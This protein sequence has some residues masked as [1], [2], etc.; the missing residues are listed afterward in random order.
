V[1]AA[2][3]ALLPPIG[4]DPW[5]G[6]VGF[7]SGASPDPRVAVEVGG[8]SLFTGIEAAGVVADVGGD[9]LLFLDGEAW[10]F[11]APTADRS[12]GAGGGGDGAILSPMP[13]RVVTVEVENGDRVSKGQRLVVL[14]AMKMEHNLVAPFDGVVG[15]LSVAAGD[16][17]AES[18]LLVRII[19]DQPA[20]QRHGAR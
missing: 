20:D 8:I 4:A 16:Q 11:A 18:L 5:E 17:V 2:A 15:D 3:A 12:P 14:E 9:Q 10:P 1:R 19:Q 6:L 7:R 13:G